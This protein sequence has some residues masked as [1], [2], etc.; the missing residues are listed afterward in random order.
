MRLCSLL[1]G[2][3]K[4]IVFSS[5]SRVVL[6]GVEKQEKAAQAPPASLASPTCPML[7]VTASA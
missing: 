6:G 5:T 4:T 1:G 3:E 2:G 7:Q